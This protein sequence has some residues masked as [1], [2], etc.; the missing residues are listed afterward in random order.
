MS[1][2]PVT[3]TLTGAGGQIG[4]AALF[5]IAS[6][7]L[8]GSQQSVRLRLLEVPQGLQA[9]EGVALEL[10]DCAFPLL[11]SV[12]IFTDPNAAFEGASVAFLVGA[13]PRTA[14]MERADLLQANGGIFG[15]QG[16]AINDHADDNIRVIVVGN[17]ANTN[18]LIAQHNA[19]DVPPERF[20]ALTRLDHNRAI[21]ILAQEARV[22]VS[23]INGITVWGNHSATQYPDLSHATISNAP[24]LDTL[25][26]LWARGEYI[27]RVAQRGAEIINTRGSSS[28]ASAANAAID[29]MRDWISGTPQRWTSVALPSDGSYGIPEGI[30][31]SFPARSVDG[32][33]KIVQGL[34]IDLFSR[35]RIEAS[36][37]ELLEEHNAVKALGLI[38]A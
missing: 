7:A 13:R 4:Y 22:H 38:P 1:A 35:E 34:T 5:R 8:L 33:W 11:H 28:A 17:P 36:V 29:H 20:T 18:A 6:G 15:P 26:P 12:D 27:R 14:G 10:T 16:R 3:I 9:A 31:S 30:V 21:G 25:D 23:E 19:P 37:N 2:Q 24:A 32:S